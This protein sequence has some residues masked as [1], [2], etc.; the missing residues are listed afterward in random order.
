MTERQT[1]IDNLALVML[2][3]YLLDLESSVEPAAK[4]IWFMSTAQ[5]ETAHILTSLHIYM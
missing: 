5:L 2:K 1:P 3:T 4:G